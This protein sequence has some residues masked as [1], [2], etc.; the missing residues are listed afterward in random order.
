METGG[1]G[2]AGLGD[3]AGHFTCTEARLASSQHPPP[4]KHWPTR[5]LLGSRG[6]GTSNWT[7]SKRGL[8]VDYEGTEDW[9]EQASPCCSGRAGE[10]GWR[11]WG[12]AR[13]ATALT[14]RPGRR[15]ELLALDYPSRPEKKARSNRPEPEAPQVPFRLAKRRPG[16][17]IAG[18]GQARLAGGGPSGAWAFLGANEQSQFPDATPN[19]RPAGGRGFWLGGGG[20]GERSELSASCKS[21]P[22]RSGHALQPVT[23]GAKMA[24]SQTQTGSPVR[25]ASVEQ[26]EDRE[27]PQVGGNLGWCGSSPRRWYTWRIWA[28]GGLVPTLW[29]A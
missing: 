7:L 9:E 20:P 27:A 22:R 8:R 6:E 17:Q 26:M 5:A 25:A 4:L 14:H 1:S 3:A 18:K 28:N 29:R 11:L 24:V 16:W 10:A 2:V 21:R 19:L 15:S 23:W 13:E 12:G